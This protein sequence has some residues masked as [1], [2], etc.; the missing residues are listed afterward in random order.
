MREPDAPSSC[1]NAGKTLGDHQAPSK[2][3]Y[4][5]KKA[6]LERRAAKPAAANLAKRKQKKSVYTNN[7]GKD[8]FLF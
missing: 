1:L 7:E 8:T 3:F 2:A 6:A 5:I 4:Q